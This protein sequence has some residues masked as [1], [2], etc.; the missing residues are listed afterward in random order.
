MILVTEVKILYYWQI[1]KGLNHHSY[2]IETCPSVIFDYTLSIF[3]KKVSTT[4]SASYIYPV[5]ICIISGLSKILA[6]NSSWS[7]ISS[8]YL[9]IGWDLDGYTISLSISLTIFIEGVCNN[10]LN[11]EMLRTAAIISRTICLFKTISVPSLS[12][13]PKYR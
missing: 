2:I 6:I 3:F 12:M 1:Y 10:F 7:L 11:D 9:W 13:Y 5:T 8:Y 4:N